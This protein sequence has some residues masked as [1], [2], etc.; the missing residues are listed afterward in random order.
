MVKT[1]VNV[2]CV[3]AIVKENHPVGYCM[4][5]EK[6]GIPNITVQQISHD[7]WKKQNISTRFVPNALNAEQCDQR[8]AHI[9]VT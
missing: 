5:E 3:A 1:D 4:I 7:N 6:T 2:A 9:H 8:I